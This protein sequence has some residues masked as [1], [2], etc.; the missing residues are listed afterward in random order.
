M[1][2]F[3]SGREVSTLSYLESQ[4][5]SPQ[6]IERFFS[7]FY[8]GIYLAPL[9]KQSA[10]MFEFVFKMFSEGGISLP[11]GGIGAIAEQLAKR[12]PKGMRDGG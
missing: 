1:C 12:L 6:M 9:E 11:K 5:L 7:P 3:W 8:R 10:R 2:I 4:G